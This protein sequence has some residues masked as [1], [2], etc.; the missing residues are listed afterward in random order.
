M[1]RSEIKALHEELRQETL[2]LLDIVWI[3]AEEQ[4]YSRFED[5]ARAS[6]LCTATLYR[7]WGGAFIR[8]QFL[9]IQK[10]CRV[11]GLSVTITSQGLETSLEEVLPNRSR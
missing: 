7:Y 9:T 2:A 6:G 5:L 4:G 8:P 11:V 10:L 1:K 3:L